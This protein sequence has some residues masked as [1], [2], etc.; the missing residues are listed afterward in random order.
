M[1]YTVTA[2]KEGY[3]GQGGADEYTYTF[4][5]AKDETIQLP[6]TQTDDGKSVVKFEFK[7]QKG[8]LIDSSL[9]TIQIKDADKNVVDPESDG[10]YILWNDAKYSYTIE[11]YGYYSASSTNF[12]VSEDGTVSIVLTEKIKIYKATITA[13]SFDTG[14]AL[15]ADIKV[16][17]TKNGVQTEVTPNQDG[18]Y[19]LDWETDY[20]ITIIAE[21][22]KTR[23]YEYKP[24]GNNEEVNLNLALSLSA[25]NQLKKAIKETEEYMAEVAEGD[26]SLEYPEGTLDAIKAA[27]DAAGEVLNK[28]GVTE[29][30]LSDAKTALDNAVRAIKKT[31]NPQIMDVPVRYQTEVDGVTVQKTLTVRGDAARKAGYLVSD[32]N[33]TVLDV[34]V[35]LHQ[36]LYGDDF[37]NDPEKYLQETSG[38]ISRIFGMKGGSFDYR[39]DHKLHDFVIGDV[40]MDEGEVL[41]IYPCED[42]SSYTKEEY[43]YFDETSVKSEEGKDLV[44]ILKGAAKDEKEPAPKE[45]YTIT[46]KN[47]ETGDLITAVSDKDGRLIFK[48]MLKGE[49]TVVSAEKEGV[50][51]VAL[52]YAQ[53]TVTE[54]AEEPEAPVY[55]VGVTVTD[56]KTGAAIEDAVIKVTD[57]DGAQV[58]QDG[59]GKYLLKADAEYKI[60]VSAPGY[61]GPDGEA[62]LTKV[63]VPSEDS[64][65]VFSLEKVN[66]DKNPSEGTDEGDSDNTE[67]GGGTGDKVQADSNIPKT[68]DETQMAAWMLAALLSLAGGSVLMRRKGEGTK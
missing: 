41:A 25:E 53:I 67:T 1:T 33:V 59:S 40:R 68:A 39:I 32:K 57:K 19:D 10:S 47:E 55:S 3:V 49:Y 9:V 24:S 5:P 16:M 15:A 18:T 46:L 64:T 17:G 62:S 56:S 12:K 37:K 45:G 36:E 4:T 38:I 54:K 23:V 65:L 13:K 28:A 43:L 26:G 7:D 48:G 8:N 44:L 63:F 29:E 14:E 35:T 20:V 22:Y 58:S 61:E 30:E 34:I 2:S 42:N 11:A 31:Q 66:E 52:P 50:K 6:L 27:I 60:E 21:G 51:H